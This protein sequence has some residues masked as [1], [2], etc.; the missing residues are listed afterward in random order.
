MSKSRASSEGATTLFHGGAVGTVAIYCVAPNIQ[1]KLCN[2][3]SLIGLESKNCEFLMLML[4]F[5]NF[6]LKIN[7]CDIGDI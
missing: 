3:I 5:S 7:F 1:G 2:R 6:L 4:I